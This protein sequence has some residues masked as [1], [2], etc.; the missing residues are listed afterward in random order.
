MRSNAGRLLS[1][2]PSP[3]K[4]VCLGA[5]GGPHAWR[6]SRGRKGRQGASS[7][8]G[9]AT[10]T[11]SQAAGITLGKDVAQYSHVCAR[12]RRRE[13]E[14]L[15][16]D[17]SNIQDTTYNQPATAMR[18]WLLDGRPGQLCADPTVRALSGWAAAM[19]VT[20]AR[21]RVAP[22]REVLGRWAAVPST[23]GIDGASGGGCA[24]PRPGPRDT[25]TCSSAPLPAGSPWMK[26]RS[27]RPMAGNN[28]LHWSHRACRRFGETRAGRDSAPVRRLAA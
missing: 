23:A 2:A 15:D 20:Y 5:F 8:E 24:P 1:R 27:P 17:G 6:K 9:V 7:P 3:A 21:S 19:R 14:T 11:P 12:M 18:E 26:P 4:P 10:V 13:T 16:D 28:C 22:R 25:G